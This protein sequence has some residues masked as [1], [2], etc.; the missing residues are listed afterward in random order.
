MASLLPDQLRNHCGKR[1]D[2]SLHEAQPP[3]SKLVVLGHGVTGNKDR[4]FL[5]A[6]ADAF[7]ENGITALRVSFSGNG[8]SEGRFAESTVSKQVKELRAVVDVLPATHLGYVGHSMGAAVGVLGASTD[9]RINFLVSLAGMAHT[10]AFVEREF[11]NVEPGGGCMWDKPECPLSPVY[12]DDMKR[13]DSV[14]PAAGNVRV[15]WLLVHGSADDVVPLQDSRDLFALAPGAKR[16]ELIEG[17]D[18]VFSDGHTAR[19]VR[20][21]VDW[22][23]RLAS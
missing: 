9:N 8:A 23:R 6:L 20:I 5:I 10:A 22:V 18:H 15:P 19:M 1:L 12:V 14:A 21:V 3:A 2:F 4:P 7:A 13:I 17:A 11:G 16:L